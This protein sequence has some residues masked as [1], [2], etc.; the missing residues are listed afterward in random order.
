MDVDIYLALRHLRNQM[1]L[2]NNARAREKGRACAMGGTG[3]QAAV[4]PREL[5]RAGYEAL[6]MESR[7]VASF[8]VPV[9]ALTAYIFGSGCSRRSSLVKGTIERRIVGRSRDAEWPTF[10]VVFFVGLRQ[11][12]VLSPSTAL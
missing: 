6:A 8:G 5:P 1:K 9:H 12:R 11:L 4:A 2:E 3:G 10:F 7:R